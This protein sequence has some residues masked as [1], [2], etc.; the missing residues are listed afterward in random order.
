MNKENLMWGLYVLSVIYCMW[1]IIKRNKKS[2]HDGVTGMS[3][4]LDIIA[5]ILLAPILAVVDIVVTWIM[6]MNTYYK[7]KK[8]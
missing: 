6:R 7:N 1:R 5:V 4:G 8:E 3:S 2:S